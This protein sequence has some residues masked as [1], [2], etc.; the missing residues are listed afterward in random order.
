MCTNFLEFLHHS[1]IKLQGLKTDNMT[2]S[3]DIGHA[4]R[5]DISSK[6]GF[7]ASRE[8]DVTGTCGWRTVTWRNVW[9]RITLNPLIQLNISTLDTI[10]F[11]ETGFLCPLIEWK[12]LGKGKLKS[13]KKKKFHAGTPRTRYV[14]EQFVQVG[15]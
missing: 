2:K 15:R 12:D 14:R 1:K 13:H 11:A 8:S 3:R 7:R 5:L 10:L 4:K 9:M 6:R